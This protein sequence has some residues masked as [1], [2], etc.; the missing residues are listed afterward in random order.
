MAKDSLQPTWKKTLSGV[1]TAI[2]VDNNGTVWAGDGAGKL[3][4][5]TSDGISSEPIYL[6][7]PICSISVDKNTNDIYVGDLA[8]NVYKYTSTGERKWGKNLGTGS[9]DAIS[10]ISTI[11]NIKPDDKGNFDLTD[12]YYSQEQIKAML[13]P[14]G[15][16]KSVNG[17]VP[18]DAGNI[19]VDLSGYYAYK[20]ALNDDSD[21]D[22]QLDTGWYALHG[23]DGGTSILL[24][25]S[26]KN[27]SG[28][29]V[30]ISPDKSISVRYQNGGKYTDWALLTNN[31]KSIN[32][33]KPDTDGNV[34]LDLTGNIKTVNNI[35]PDKDGNIQLGVGSI[36][37]VKSVNN[38]YYPDKT[39]N[40][41]VPQFSLN[42]LPNTSDKPTE[43]KPDTTSKGDNY[44]RGQSGNVTNGRSYSAHPDNDIGTTVTTDVSVDP[45]TT[46]IASFSAWTQENTSGTAELSGHYT[47]W[48]NPKIT[49]YILCKDDTGNYT[50]I[51]K[52]KYHFK[53]EDTQ[54][55]GYI[56]LSF[57]TTADTKTVELSYNGFERTDENLIL[58][59]NFSQA[60]SNVYNNSHGSFANDND[61]VVELKPMTLGESIAGKDVSIRI[62]AYVTNY[63]KGSF[64]TL[65]TKDMDGSAF[66][67]DSSNLDSNKRL[68]KAISDIDENNLVTGNGFYS[69]DY[70]MSANEL[71]GIDTNTVIPITNIVGNIVYTV[72]IVANDG[73]SEPDMEW[74]AGYST[75][76][77][78]NHYYPEDSFNYLSLFNLELYNKDTANVV[79]LATYKFSDLSNNLT[80]TV[81][82]Y[83][84]SCV[85]DMGD[86]TGFCRLVL[87]KYDT[88]TDTV[89]SEEVS[90]KLPIIDLDDD[91]TF[92][93]INHSACYINELQ[94]D[95]PKVT[96]A[97]RLRAYIYGQTSSIYINKVKLAKWADDDTPPD[98]NWLPNLNDIGKVQSVNGILPDST[99]DIILHGIDNPDYDYSAKDTFDVDKAT[100]T[101]VYRFMDSKVIASIKPDA[102]NGLFTTQNGTA[103]CGYLFVLKHDNFNREQIL[104]LNHGSSDQDTQIAIRSISGT[105]NWRPVFRRLLCIDDYL[106]LQ[107]YVRDLSFMNDD[108]G[109]NIY[110]SDINM[111]TYATMGITHFLGCRIKSSGS[112]PEFD[113]YLGKDCYGW[114]FNTPHYNNANEYD[115]LLYMAGNSMGSNSYEPSLYMRSGYVKSYTTPWIK[116][117]TNVDIDKGLETVNT[118]SNPMIVDEKTATIDWLNSLSESGV[119][120]IP[121]TSPLSEDKGL[122][123][124]GLDKFYPA[125]IFVYSNFDAGSAVT[126]SIVQPTLSKFNVISRNGLIDS[127]GNVYS[128][129]AWHNIASDIDNVKNDLTNLKGAVN[130]KLN[131]LDRVRYANNEVDA[132]NLSRDHR[133]IIYYWY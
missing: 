19:T 43:I 111:D 121:N 39:G 83:S 11:N 104:F 70:T 116:L 66:K 114:I 64:F 78:G 125:F 119:Y 51:Y 79:D 17:N 36:N 48:R 93:T 133:G 12:K 87:Q 34:N 95:N 106:N 24:V 65:K 72:K 105:N 60:D 115:T 29:Q 124:T 109:R 4:R 2:G 69:W 89:I 44:W 28:L 102:L 75:T 52:Y 3:S 47:M 71:V 61:Q 123:N 62:Q 86:S 38:S 73:T 81:G 6:D 80:S 90:K 118:F 22:K 113:S 110:S 14:L 68:I 26:G 37:S 96:E 23:G 131:D 55:M 27:V 126:Q 16:T 9:I 108:A 13:A 5:F 99:G 85:L 120:Y 107:R 58:E 91:G 50:K 31:I 101:G 41:Q 54:Y 46:Y 15:K 59:P 56:S 35:K 67:L 92:E 20:G 130:D 49:F 42:L 1:I 10:I 21:L 30:R 128:L 94:N 98:L 112:I 76:A 88:K 127:S 18:N 117:S 33:I 129:Q 7:N 74:T 122:A 57:E 84:A 82:K 132:V 32:H 63:K 8:N 45:N 100:Q 77:L 40:V 25:Y 97:I 103:M 53:Q